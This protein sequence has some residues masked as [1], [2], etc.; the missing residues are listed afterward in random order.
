M[1]I[2][3][4]LSVLIWTKMRIRE[5]RHDALVK[6]LEFYLIFLFDS[7]HLMS[8]MSVEIHWHLNL[9]NSFSL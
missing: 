4:H 5:S 7:L 2:E 6:S 1:K 3:M 8:Y 9:L